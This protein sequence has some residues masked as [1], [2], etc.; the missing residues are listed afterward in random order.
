MRSL[1]QHYLKAE[2]LRRNQSISE[3]LEKSSTKW[4]KKEKQKLRLLWPNTAIYPQFALSWTSE[5][6]VNVNAGTWEVAAQGS[7]IEGQLSF[8]N[9]ASSENY[10]ASHT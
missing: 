2:V 6:F 3:L 10:H 9:K 7:N 4:H 5:C 1:P 8:H